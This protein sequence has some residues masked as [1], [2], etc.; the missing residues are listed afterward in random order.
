MWRSTSFGADP[1]VIFAMSL[2][3]STLSIG[4]HVPTKCDENEPREI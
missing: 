3:S 2:K 1:L 4:F